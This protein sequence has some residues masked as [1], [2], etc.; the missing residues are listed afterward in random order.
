MGGHLL[1]FERLPVAGPCMAF[2]PPGHA[3][4]V[5]DVIGL[6]EQRLRPADVSLWRGMGSL[7]AERFT[8]WH[9]GVVAPTDA[10]VVSV[11]D[12]EP[13]RPSISFARDAPKVLVINPLRAGKNLGA[14]AGNHVVLEVTGGFVL[15]AHLRR[16]S[17]VPTE[18][19]A[20]TPG[21]ELGKVGNSGNSLVPHLHVQAMTSA[22]PFAAAVLPWQVTALDRYLD[23]VWRFAPGPVPLR[24]PI[25]SP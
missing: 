15:L 17:V 1:T 20:V 8:G 25:R 4:H 13:D 11:H 19:D 9:R 5:L 10:M 24:A 2:R 6:D 21:D 7:R 12:G 23:G 22:D 14:M 16:G 18:G 3:Q